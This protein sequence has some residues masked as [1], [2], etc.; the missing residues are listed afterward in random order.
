M[1]HGIGARVDFEE[2]LAERFCPGLEAG[3]AEET[4]TWLA[5]KPRE[6]QMFLGAT[7]HDPD[8]RKRV[9]NTL[10]KIAE[11][12]GEAGSSNPNK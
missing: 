3:E 12:M 1:T 8:Q 6:D 9:L 2:L 7:R 10:S 5:G 11:F 4:L